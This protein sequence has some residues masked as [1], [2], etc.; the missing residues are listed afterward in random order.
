MFGDSL[1]PDGLFCADHFRS[2]FEIRE[3]IAVIYTEIIIRNRPGN[4]VIIGFI[5]IGGFGPVLGPKFEVIE[6]YTG[7][8]F[9]VGKRFLSI[10][11]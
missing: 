10:C 5:R 2:V 8:R 9:L 4:D 11:E 1:F 7:T 3:D 6:V